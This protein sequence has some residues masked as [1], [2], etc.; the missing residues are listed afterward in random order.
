MIS[1]KEL[2]DEGESLRNYYEDLKSGNYFVEKASFFEWST[3][4]LMYLQDM[5]SKH[6]QIE[7]LKKYILKEDVSFEAFSHMIAILKAFDVIKPSLRPILYDEI[8]T[9]IFNKFHIVSKKLKRRHNN[10]DTIELN[11]EYDVQDL[12]H[13][14]LVLHFEDVRP[15]EWTPS[16]AGGNNRMDFLIEDGEIAIEVKMTRKGLKDKEVGEQLII[17]ITKYNSHP[18]CKSLYCFVYDP[19]EVIRN[20]RGIEK[21]LEAYSSGISVK[22]YIRPAL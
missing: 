17:D 16:Y 15:E 7:A 14:L 4:A 21:D 5:F 6:P 20:P 13:G 11:D 9:T 22:V 10:R 3:K 18:H 8:L 19:D 12:L 2:I 1:L